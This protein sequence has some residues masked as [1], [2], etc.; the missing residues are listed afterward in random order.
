MQAS[1][2]TSNQPSWDQLTTVLDEFGDGV[3][4]QAIV[5]IVVVI[6]IAGVEGFPVPLELGEDASSLHGQQ[7]LSQ[8]HRFLQLSLRRPIPFCM[9]AVCRFVGSAVRFQFV[10]QPSVDPSHFRQRDKD[11]G[12]SGQPSLPDLLLLEPAKRPPHSETSHDKGRKRL[13]SELD[14]LPHNLLP[15]HIQAY[16]RPG[17]VAA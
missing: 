15:T 8:R 13:S 9:L 16:S 7:E 6:L 4:Q 12:V 5:S 10:N 2:R 1:Q 11:V 17:P 3:V 14:G